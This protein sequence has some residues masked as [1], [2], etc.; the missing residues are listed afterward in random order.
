MKPLRHLRCEA[1]AK[2]KHP[3]DRHAGKRRGQ[4]ASH[5]VGLLRDADDVV[6]L[7]GVVLV[8]LDL[9][10]NKR[11][12]HSDRGCAH[13]RLRRRPGSRRFG[14]PHFP[15]TARPKAFLRPSMRTRVWSPRNRNVT[16]S[17]LDRPADLVRSSYNKHSKRAYTT[18]SE[19]RS[20]EQRLRR[21]DNVSPI[22]LNPKPVQPR[23]AECVMYSWTR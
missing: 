19:R 23:R 7:L 8:L 5:R 17:H 3:T 21:E 6:F 4:P 22:R 9:H 20:N 16:D 1:R 10:K 12:P 14:D 11:H 18:T 13:R 15:G 2:A